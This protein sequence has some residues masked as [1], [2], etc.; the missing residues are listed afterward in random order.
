MEVTEDGIVICVNLEHPSKAL[1]P[2]DVTEE[3]IVIC[4]NDEHLKKA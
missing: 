1:Y 3:E 4:V 2:I